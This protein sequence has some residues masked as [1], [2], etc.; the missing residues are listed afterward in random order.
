[1]ATG[2]VC[3]SEAVADEV[4]TWLQQ[5]PP[6]RHAGPRVG[7][8]HLGADVESSSPSKGLPDNAAPLLRL[9][10]T[11]PSFLTVGTLEPRKGH[12]QM[13]AA[14]EQ[15]WAQGTDVN[16]VF[17][18]K[19]GWMMEPLVQQLQH[20]AELGKRLF[21]LDGISDEYLEK[22]YAASHCLIAGSEGEGF[23]LPLIEAARHKLPIIARDLPVFREVAGAHAYYFAGLEAA[24]LAAAVLDWRALQAQGLAPDSARMPFLTWTESARQLLPQILQHTVPEQT[25]ESSGS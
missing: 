6:I 7:S 14:F 2:L 20:H 3:I 24:P 8:F 21:W 13:L 15:L 1:V 9:L 18:G 5:H 11:R 4:Q 12:V 25:G 19:K 16:L 17:I 22:V 23:G 10:K